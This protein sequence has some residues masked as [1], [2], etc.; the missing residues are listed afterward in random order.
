MAGGP[1][2]AGA[3]GV[4]A[5]SAAREPRSWTPYGGVCA[6]VAVARPRLIGQAVTSQ[7]GDAGGRC[8]VGGG[9]GG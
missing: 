8:A 2:G 3:T 9:P 7:D 1:A 5:A 6:G 4:R